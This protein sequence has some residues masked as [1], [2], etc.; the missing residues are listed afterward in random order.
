MT[1]ILPTPPFLAPTSAYERQ[2]RTA[3]NWIYWI[4]GLTFL[5]MFVVVFGKDW[6]FGTNM[7]L[8]LMIAY[9]GHDQ[10]IPLKLTAAFACTVC[11]G[12]FALLGF[13]TAKTARWAIILAAVFYGI[14]GIIWLAAQQWIGAAIHAFGLWRLCIGVQ[15]AFALSKVRPQPVIG[16]QGVRAP[17][18]M[19]PPGVWPAAPTPPDPLP[20]APP[21]IMPGQA[22]PAPPAPPPAHQPPAE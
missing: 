14:D 9:L 17:D 7:L 8:P 10:A 15:A 5:N 18:N 3:A 20:P 4:A 1:P 2:V 19:Q 22:Y 6:E 16:Y 21:P 11:C 13:F 12:I